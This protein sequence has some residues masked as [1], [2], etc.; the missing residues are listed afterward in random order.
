MI[1]IYAT[2]QSNLLN[3]EIVRPDR[4]QHEFI[5]GITEAEATRRVYL[6]SREYIIEKLTGWLKQRMFTYGPQITNR[7]GLSVEASRLLVLLNYYQRASLAAVCSVVTDHAQA[8]E[9]LAPG[10]N[11]EHYGRYQKVIAPIIAFCRVEKGK[12]HE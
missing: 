1:T 6:I 5:N 12:S 4:I 8:L 9:A 3:L 2:M 7:P 10:V 11:S